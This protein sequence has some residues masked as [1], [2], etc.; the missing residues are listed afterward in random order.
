MS[1]ILVLKHESDFRT[2]IKESNIPVLVE[3]YADWC[4]PCKNIGLFLEEKARQVYIKLL[5]VNVDDFPNIA[6]EYVTRGIPLIVLFRNGKKETD[7]NR[8]D[9]VAMNNIINN[10]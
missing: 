8:F 3:F 4:G 1:N 2:I 7:F 9:T 5:K 10:M 6:K